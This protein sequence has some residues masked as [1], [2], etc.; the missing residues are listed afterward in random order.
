MTISRGRRGVALVLV[1]WLIVV[2]GAITAAVVASSRSGSQVLVNAR[3]RI[4]ARYASESGIVAARPLLQQLAFAY[5][6]SQQVLAITALNG[7]M[8]DLQE[9]DLGAARFG[10]TLTDLNARLDLNQSDP[11]AVVGLI[12]EFT[13]RS[14][15]QSIG[16]ALLDWRDGDDLVRSQGAEKE[17]YQ[18]A[19][20]AYVPRNAPLT[21]LD[22]LL[23]IRGVTDSLAQMLDPYITVNS[24]FRLDVNAAP[25]P[26]LAAFPGIGIGGARELIARRQS[27]PFTSVSE[28]LTLLRAGSGGAD[29]QLPV[30]AVAPSRLLVT[31]RGWMPG[32]PLTH[33]IEAVYAVGQRQLTLV[34]WRE[35]DR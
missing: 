8:Q 23:R 20:S 34:S 22:E 16:D 13:S 30:L 35:R 31:S 3:T 9:V 17:A 24:D 11:E 7:A 6:P 10:V 14:A 25:E 26:V 32:H 15:A 4:V 2:L 19:G 5:S 33:E 27:G 1:L 18:R 21:R 28:V 29:G 12:S